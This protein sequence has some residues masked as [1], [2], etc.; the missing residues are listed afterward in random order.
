MKV[1]RIILKKDSTV[2]FLEQLW[3]KLYIK[4]SR[5]M[6]VDVKSILLV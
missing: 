1:Y 3:I 4:T 5:M 6:T 2:E